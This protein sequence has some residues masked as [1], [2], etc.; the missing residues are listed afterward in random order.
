MMRRFDALNRHRGGYLV[1]VRE[2]PATP[3]EF[4]CMTGQVRRSLGLMLETAGL[5]ASGLKG[6]LR[7]N[8]LMAIY[9]AALN[10]LGFVVVTVVFLTIVLRAL[11]QSSWRLALLGSA[12]AT[13]VVYVVFSQW[14]GAQLPQGALMESV[15]A[16]I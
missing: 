5:S 6:V 15:R 7:L 8:G 9:A 3:L 12:A 11:E 1:L 13:I 4:G 10:T 2:L 16:W 14:L